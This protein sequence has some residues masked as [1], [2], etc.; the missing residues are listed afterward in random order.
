[1][2]ERYDGR[3]AYLGQVERAARALV[4]QRLMLAGDVAPALERAA[5]AW[6]AVVDR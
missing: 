2:A 5:A 4:D 3:Q 6:T 1:V